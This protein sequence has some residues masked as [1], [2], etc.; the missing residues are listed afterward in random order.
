LVEEL[1][2]TDNAERNRMVL[3]NASAV[4]A[5]ERAAAA[6]PNDARAR[7]RVGQARDAAGQCDKARADFERAIALDP[8]LDEA[9]LR[10][11]MNAAKCGNVKA[12]RAQLEVLQRRDKKMAA[13]LD[14]AIK[15]A[16]TGPVVVAV[17]PNE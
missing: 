3:A 10:L 14:A 11:G 1:G 13:E 8:S 12:A 4:D 5:A 6:A 17:N 15:K 9:R 2:D 7:M 16:P